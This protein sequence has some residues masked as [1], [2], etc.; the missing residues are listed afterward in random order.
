MKKILIVDD[1]E[2]IVE[3]LTVV[4]EDAGYA[5]VS[6]FDGAEVMSKIREHRPDLLLIDLVMPKQEGIETIRQVR[7]ANEDLP[8]IAMSSFNQHY[9]DMV[10][11]LGANRSVTKPFDMPKLLGQ[12]EELLA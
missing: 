2:I 6:A 8:I 11:G 3:L 10:Q 5:T 12:I 7:K 4:L 9:L 1:D